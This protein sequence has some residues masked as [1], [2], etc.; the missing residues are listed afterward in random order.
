M[1]SRCLLNILCALVFFCLRLA[2]EDLPV[3]LV[4]LPLNEGENAAVRN[5]AN[6]AIPVKLVHPEL[7]EWVDGPE[8][9][10]LCFKNSHNA[11]QRALLSCEIPEE[12]DLCAEFTLCCMIK[13]P[14]NL[15]RSRQYELFNYADAD[16]APGVRVFISWRMLW[17]RMNDSR[18]NYTL[19]THSP[20]FAINP[21]TWYFVT[22]VFDGGKGKLFLNAQLQEEMTMSMIMP[23]RRKECYLGASSPS[24][25]GYGFEG[26]ITQFKLFTQA[27]NQEQ[28]TFLYLQ[29]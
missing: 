25:S 29:H 24:G 10:A 21:D 8:G 28:I 27:L 23:R 4:H 5:I 20:R 14:A 26:L 22:V 12:L 11:T 7:L 18:Q 13:T 15:H 2:G 17:L 9:K 3:P 19:R 1:Y 6:E 16:Y